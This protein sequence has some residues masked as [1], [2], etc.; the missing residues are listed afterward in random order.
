MKAFF[1]RENTFGRGSNPHSQ[2][3]VSWI[4]IV[5]PNICFGVIRILMD[6]TS[7]ISFM[8]SDQSLA[9]L[10]YINLLAYSAIYTF[11]WIVAG[12]LLAFHYGIWVGN[13][14]ASV[15]SRF[16]LCTLKIL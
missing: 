14:G 4:R 2:N 3:Q 11:F 7:E 8:F 13:A 6:F 5:H 12:I 1:F 10:Q 9:F 16:Y 15:R